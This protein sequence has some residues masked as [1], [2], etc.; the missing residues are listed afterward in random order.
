MQYTVVE[1]KPQGKY[2]LFEVQRHLE[3]PMQ[4]RAFQFA[5]AAIISFMALLIWS[6][7]SILSAS[8]EALVVAALLDLATHGSE[9][10]SR[11]A[12]GWGFEKWYPTVICCA[13]G[14]V[15]GL[16][17]ADRMRPS[18]C[19]PFH[20]F[21]WPGGL[22]CNVWYVAWTGLGCI[23]WYIHHRRNENKIPTTKD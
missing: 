6:T 1:S 11:Y 3:N 18:H 7:S 8:I 4:A 19:H 17:L 21:W 20:P 5:G 9:H 16:Y 10:A 13:L 14:I 15:S 23:V 2:K 12:H 22:L